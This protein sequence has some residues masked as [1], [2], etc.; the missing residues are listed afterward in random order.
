MKEDVLVIL[1]TGFGK[2]IIYQLLPKVL[3]HCAIRSDTAWIYPHVFVQICQDNCC[4]NATQGEGGT[5]YQAL[6]PLLP[7]SHFL[8][9]GGGEGGPDRRLR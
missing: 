1:P 6:L 5:F 7:F 3:A 2:S 4:A 8:L 9:L